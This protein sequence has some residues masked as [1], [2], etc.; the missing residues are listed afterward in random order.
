MHSHLKHRG[1]H[2]MLVHGIGDGTLKQAIRT[3][4][5]ITYAPSCSWNPYGDGATALTVK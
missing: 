3:E 2:V 1:R 5:D 4:L